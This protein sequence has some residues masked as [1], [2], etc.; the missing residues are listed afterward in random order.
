[1]SEPHEVQ[2]SFGEHLDELRRRLLYAVAGL[3]AAMGVC[4]YF[5]R[6]LVY[7]LQAPVTEALRIAGQDPKLYATNVVDPFMAYL[8]VSLIAAVFLASPWIALQLWKFVAVG[9]FPTER[10]TLYIFA[11]ATVLLFVA[12]T[13]F[14]YFV[15]VRYGIQFLDRKSVV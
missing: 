5:G 14:S 3:A 10:R 9:L 15:L 7:V 11:P 13:V 2:M 8:K 1:M 12:G 4:L 6:D